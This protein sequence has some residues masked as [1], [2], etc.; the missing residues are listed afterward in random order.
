MHHAYKWRLQN[1]PQQ[2]RNVSLLKSLKNNLISSSA[3]QQM[4]T[5]R[6]YLSDFEKQDNCFQGQ[7]WAQLLFKSA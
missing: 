1:E 6:I 7:E 4:R 3:Q 2:R 5:H